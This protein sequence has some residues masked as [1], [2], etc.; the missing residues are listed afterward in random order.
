MMRLRLLFLPMKRMLTSCFGLGLLP[1]CPGTWGSLPP[2]VVFMTLALFGI[3]EFVIVSIM[4]LFVILGLIACVA[5]SPAIMEKTGKKDPGEIVA[6]EFA[7]QAVAL[8]PAAFFSNIHCCFIAIICFGFF[9]LFDITKPFPIRKLEK[10]PKG[11]G[12][13]ADDLMAGVYAA[14]LFMI[15]AFV[16][17]YRLSM[18]P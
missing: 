10:F 15:V 9:R 18:T 1:L 5:F 12:I 6:D 13:L 3:P 8:L 11:W 7:G 16:W 17:Q 4:G 2:V 14:I